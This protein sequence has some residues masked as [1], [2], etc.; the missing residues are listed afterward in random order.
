MIYKENLSDVLNEE[1]IEEL[2]DQV[3]QDVGKVKRV[4]LIHPDYTRHDFTDMIVPKLLRMLRRK[5]LKEFHTLNASGTH[6]GMKIGE[7]EEKLGI[8]QS[9]D[10]IFHNHEFFVPDQLKI[11]GELP[12]DFVAKETEG[13]IEE[14]IPVNVNKMIFDNFDAIFVLSGT[15]PHESAGFAG[16]LKA[17]IPG[18]SG[19]RVVDTFHWAAVLVGIPKI[20][21]TINN[22]AR[23]I[24]NEASRLVFEKIGVPVFSLNMIFEEEPGKVLPKG[25]Y[26]AEGFEGFLKAYEKACEASSKI[27][28]RYLDRPIKRA[29][30]VIGKEYDE[31]WTAGK[32]SYKLQRPGVMVLGGEIIIYAPHIYKFHSN[33]DMDR[34]IREIGYHCK[35]YVK[36]FLKKHPNFSKNVA[37]HVINVRGPGSY[38]SN[39]GKEEFLFKVTLATK[40]SKEECEAAN[41]GYMDPEKVRREDFEDE[42]SLWIELGGRYLYDL[43][44]R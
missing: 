21:G 22:P 38:D 25:L 5:G 44:K 33:K 41:L 36:E 35:D 24:I 34:W 29:I 2:L 7:I 4:L 30:Q 14:P 23:S 8:K 12:K 20:I 16:G 31:V 39:T 32:G 3:L 17:F 42:E 15:I 37:S 6:R 27:H 1:D 11:I 18:I 19:P 40:I 43:K 9:E 10:V 13:E 28:I 26:I